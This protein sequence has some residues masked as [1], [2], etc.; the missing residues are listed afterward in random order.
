MWFKKKKRQALEITD[1]QYA[2]SSIDQEFLEATNQDYQNPTSINNELYTQNNHSEFDDQ[3]KYQTT[4][5][6]FEQS[7]T[8]NHDISSNA[9][10]FTPTKFSEV[11]LIT[12]TLLENKVVLV[13]LKNL[14][15]DTKKR[16]KN[17]IAGVL[18]VKNGEY[19]KLHE[20]IYKFIIRN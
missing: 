2:N 6:Y 1:M 20:M 19:I 14:D 7:S 5:H 9:N 18:Y 17:F 16:F 8:I 4:D 3:T 15:T 10:I 12:D 11:Q 13:D